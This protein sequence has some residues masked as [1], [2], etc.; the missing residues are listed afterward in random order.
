MMC[1][2]RQSGVGRPRSDLSL[3]KKED[4]EK[5]LES[6]SGCLTNKPRKTSAS[7]KGISWLTAAAAADA[8]YP[9]THRNVSVCQ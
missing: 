8:R 5:R 4:L 3:E 2:V 1:A 6:M 7:G 9:L